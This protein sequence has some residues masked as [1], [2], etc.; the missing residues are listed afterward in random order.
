MPWGA[1]T[2]GGSFWYDEPGTEQANWETANPYTATPGLV[3]TIYQ[4]P[5]SNQ[6]D[7]GPIAGDYGRAIMSQDQFSGMD[8]WKYLG[9]GDTTKQALWNYIQTNPD[10]IYA[11]EMIKNAQTGGWSFNPVSS[12]TELWAG[13]PTA[14]LSGQAAGLDAFLNQANAYNP[15]GLTQQQYDL[16]KDFMTTGGHFAREQNENTTLSDALRPLTAAIIAIGSG[17]TLGGA[18]GAL[19]AAANTGMQAAQ[20]QDLGA[21]TI[22]GGLTS[23]FGAAAAPA[24]SAGIAG[25]LGEAGLSE[26]LAS[27][28]G[29]I[30]SAG[31]MSAIKG[32]SLENIGTSLLGAGLNSTIGGLTDGVGEIDYSGQDLSQPDFSEGYYGGLGGSMDESGYGDLWGDWSGYD[33]GSGTDTSGSDLYGNYDAGYGTTGTEAP[34]NTG[35]YGSTGGGFSLTSLAPM[36]L[37]MLGG[38]GTTSGGTTGGTTGGTGSTSG[39][40]GGIGDIFN[41]V[42]DY[43]TL[44]RSSDFLKQIM[45]QTGQY[46]D[47]YKQY[48]PQEAAMRNQTFTD[49]TAMYNSDVYQ[50]LD[51]RLQDQQLAGAAQAGTLY[52]APERLAQRQTNFY[53]YLSKLRSDLLPGSGAG[54]NPIAPQAA[55]A[56]MM[57]SYVPLE[58]AKASAVGSG[59]NAGSTMVQQ[60]LP[61][62]M[63]WLESMGGG[64]QGV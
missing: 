64:A 55:Q 36:L 45:D 12:G 34:A 9:Y 17:G 63:K 61:D 15:L 41:S 10:D 5:G 4:G 42:Y 21:N 7:M 20:G 57:K 14:Q 13:D 60:S 26:G 47:P 44:D 28:G 19:A 56:E 33:W 32:G 2:D 25:Q 37:K 50:S 59:V 30:G 24:L 49:P 6:A 52:N 51:K 48:R 23:G 1:D 53:D 43:N 46:G 16:T 22:M 62:I 27:A 29:N 58:M 31:T 8:L 35:D 3:S 38:G 18:G 11:Q 40:Y 54:L 39:T